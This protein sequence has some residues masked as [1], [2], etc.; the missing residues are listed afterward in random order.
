M[1]F[2]RYWTEAGSEIQ[3][4][5]KKVPPG[6]DKDKGN[7]GG[8]WTG[9]GGGWG[10]GGKGG[11]GDAHWAAV[12]LLV[13]FDG[14]NGA[15]SAVD[16]SLNELAMTFTGDA[17]LSNLL[18]FNGSY[19][20]S[21]LLDGANDRVSINTLADYI[22]LR[23]GGDPFTVEARIRF[24][25]VGVDFICGYDNETW[26]WMVQSNE[27]PTFDDKRG[28]VSFTAKVAVLPSQPI[29]TWI[30]VA[31]TFDGTDTYMAYLAGILTNTQGPDVG[32]IPDGTNVPFTIGATAADASDYRGNIQAIRITRAD[33]YLGGNYTPLD[34]W[35]VSSAD[36][37]L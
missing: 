6:K 10:K 26:R 12:E 18:S 35:S 36:I 23:L 30:D 9:R 7:G 14:A 17:Q 15:T 37:L 25:N 29:N 32:D 1:A 5:P 11:G 8:G 31:V 24:D 4:G 22:K 20:T 19:T 27:R 21:L 16:E 2:S 3:T 28:G 13:N 33:R 34:R